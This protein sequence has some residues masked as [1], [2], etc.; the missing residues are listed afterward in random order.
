[1][2]QQYIY[3]DTSVIGGCEDEEFSEDTLKL[4]EYFLNGTYMQLLSELT[5]RELSGAPQS[6]RN[7]IAEIPDVHQLLLPDSEEAEQL[8]Q[9][10][11]DHGIVGAGSQ[12]D[13]L[14]VA[15]ASVGRADVLVSWNFKHI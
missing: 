3:V 6:V 8:A 7:R 5:I 14:H 11:L 12:A 9:K 10:Y 15:L 13:A 4:W 1:M 2:R